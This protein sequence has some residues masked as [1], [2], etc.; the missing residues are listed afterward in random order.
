MSTKT[1]IT[2]LPLKESIYLARPA[3]ATS[4]IALQ[5][6]RINDGSVE[7]L[8]DVKPNARPM[9]RLLKKFAL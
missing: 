9:T 4:P 5:A 7:P 2:F 8:L 3:K 1:P 6:Q